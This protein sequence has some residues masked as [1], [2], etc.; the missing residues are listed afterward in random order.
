MP[1]V[2][3]KAGFSLSEPRIRQALDSTSLGV[4]GI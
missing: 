3:D 1:T 2:D 4:L